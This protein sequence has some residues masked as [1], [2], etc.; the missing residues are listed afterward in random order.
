M[1]FSKITFKSYPLTHGLFYIDI[2]PSLIVLQLCSG[3]LRTN[4]LSLRYIFSSQRACTIGYRYRT[5][6][7]E[8]PEHSMHLSTER[9][10]TYKSEREK[11]K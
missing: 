8:V 4:Q 7:R 11:R 2:S 3:F 6:Y 9:E 5:E 10:E 1:D